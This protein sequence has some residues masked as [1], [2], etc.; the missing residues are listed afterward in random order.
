MKILKTILFT[1]SLIAAMSMSAQNVDEILNKYFENTGGLENWKK[2]EAI[3]SKGVMKMQGM[4]I[5]FNSYQSKDGKMLQKANFQGKEVIFLASDGETAWGVN[6]MTMKPEKKDNETLE[7]LKKQSKDVPSP[8]IDYKQKGYVVTLDG[9]KEIDGAPCYRI[10]LEKDSLLIDGK[11][12]PGIEYYYFD[13]ENFVP[14]MKESPIPAGPMAGQSAQ[15]FI[16]N[17]QE[18]GDLYIPFEMTSKVNGNVV[19][20]MVMNKFEINPDFDASVLKFPEEEQKP[21]PAKPAPDSK[22]PAEGGGK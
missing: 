11:M 8:F 2:V 3:N 18:V 13:K 21:T 7:N 20:S 19:Q 14:I 15:T 22:M 9:E 6:F 5:P 17:Y 16:S 4:E 10:K 1:L 12:I